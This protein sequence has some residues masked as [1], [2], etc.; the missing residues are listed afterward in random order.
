[1]GV[2]IGYYGNRQP[3]N[4]SHFDKLIENATIMYMNRQRI[5]LRSIKSRLH[6]M[7]S[8]QA[9]SRHPESVPHKWSYLCN[10]VAIP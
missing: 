7:Q 1:M 10:G 3:S 9:R 4:E 2:A 6:V 5:A 8:Q